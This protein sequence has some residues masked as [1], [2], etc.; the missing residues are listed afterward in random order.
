MQEFQKVN[1]EEIHK[2]KDQ[3]QR[4]SDTSKLKENFLL[5]G[6]TTPSWYQSIVTQIS[7]II[8]TLKSCS[9][10]FTAWIWYYRQ[11]STGTWKCYKDYLQE[12]L[13]EVSCISH[14]TFIARFSATCFELLICILA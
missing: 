10:C 7:K 12:F 11:Q 14:I 2:L 6:Q 3:I 9:F 5:M 8:I 4:S 1:E 13:F